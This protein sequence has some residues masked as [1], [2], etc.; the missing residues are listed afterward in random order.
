MRS[1]AAFVVV[2]GL[3]FALAYGAGG[4]LGVPG[5]G[6]VAEEPAAGE[7]DDHSPAEHAESTGER[8]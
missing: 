1:L 7:H 2:L 4:L 8:P 6:P 5:G 3:V